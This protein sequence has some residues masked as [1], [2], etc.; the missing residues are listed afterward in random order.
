MSGTGPRRPWL[1]DPSAGG[2]LVRAHRPSSAGAVGAAVSDVLWTDVLRVV[3]W[4][5]ATLDCRPVLV[6]GTAWRTAAASAGL[7]RRLPGLCGEVGLTW[8]GVAATSGTEGSA[9]ERLRGATDR[10][11]GHLRSP[12]DEVVD[13]DLLAAV[14]ADAVGAAAVAL[15]AEEADWRVRR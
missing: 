4:A 15:L 10:L 2:L 6:D 1:Y 12:A 9:R 5:T 11:S 3:R 13:A 14:A 8:G 7:L